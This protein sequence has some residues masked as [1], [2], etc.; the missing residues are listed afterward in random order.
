[1]APYKIRDMLLSDLRKVRMGF[2]KHECAAALDRMS[3]AEKVKAGEVLVHINIAIKKLETIDLQ[4]IADQ[5]VQFE[6]DLTAA[7]KRLSEAVRN[8]AKFEKVVDA[9][10]KVVSLLGKIARLVGLPLPASDVA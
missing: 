1:M 7:S 2:F 4:D 3:D 9:A 5:L 10:G 8:L 6:Q